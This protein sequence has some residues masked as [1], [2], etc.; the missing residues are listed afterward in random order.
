MKH[1]HMGLRIPPKNPKRPQLFC[2]CAE[3]ETSL[4]R[5]HFSSFETHCVEDE[6]V[7]LLMLSAYYQTPLIS[8]TVKL[9]QLFALTYEN[10]NAHSPAFQLC[11]S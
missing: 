11:H 6:G 2:L 4:L 9:S 7:T 1:G 3:S 8:S 5:E 10:E